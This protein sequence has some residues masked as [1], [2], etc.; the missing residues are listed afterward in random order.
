MPLT[1]FQTAVARTLAS[2]RS[3]DSYLAGGAAIH[4]APNSRRYSNALDY[5]ADSEERVATAFDGDRAALKAAGFAVNVLLERPGFVRAIVSRGEESTKVEWVHDTAWR[6]L[7]VVAD[8]SVGFRLHPVDLSLNK[9]LALVGREEPRDFLDTLDAHE[10]TLSLG[11]QVWA[12]AGKDPGFTPASLLSLL[13]RRG[14]YRP[15]DFARLHLV[16]APDLPSLKTRWHSALEQAADFIASRPPAELGCLYYSPGQEA[17]PIDP[18]GVADCVPHYGRPG[19][20]Y[21]LVRS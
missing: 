7:P 10:G 6:F 11:A 18:T 8:E 3:E 17:F 19:G 2:L 12:A 16:E 9:L 13:R 4:L 14:H 5:F 15:E 21:P 20:V 1:P